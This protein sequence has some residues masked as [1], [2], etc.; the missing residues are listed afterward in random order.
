MEAKNLLLPFVAIFPIL[1]FLLGLAIFGIKYVK[2]V[3][4]HN[5][6][7]KESKL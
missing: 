5:K 3:K 1:M 7:I 6:H 2:Q 4:E